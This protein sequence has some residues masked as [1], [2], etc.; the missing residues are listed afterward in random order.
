MAGKQLE[1]SLKTA[2]ATGN[3]GTHIV[4]LAVYLLVL[5]LSAVSVIVWGEAACREAGA[6]AGPLE[7]EP[8]TGSPSLPPPAP[9]TGN[10]CDCG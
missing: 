4:G 10:C 3:G 5:F 1:L 2:A 6:R 8:M 9:L 7:E